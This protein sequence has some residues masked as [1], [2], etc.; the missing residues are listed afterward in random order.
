MMQKPRPVAMV[1]AMKHVAVMFD[2]DGTLADTLADIAAAGNHMLSELDRPTRSLSAFRYLAGQGI[3]YLVEH[4][5]EKDHDEAIVQRG[6]DLVRSYYAKQGHTHVQPYPGIASLLDELASRGITLAVLT[7][8]PQAPAQVL[9]ETL[10]AR[11]SFAAVCGAQE[12]LALKPDP[13]GAKQISRELA[14]P[15]EHW[16]YVGDT[17]VDMLTGKAAGLFTVGVTWGFRD[18]QEL[19]D[20][21]SDAIVHEP[22][23]ILDLL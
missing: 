7:N 9:M 21:G 14:I 5:L 13:A 4:A 10:Y 22:M 12:G 3:R 2:L 1:L 18:E 19:R 16:L 20:N 15:P 23:A 17:K 11:W 8:K 6:I